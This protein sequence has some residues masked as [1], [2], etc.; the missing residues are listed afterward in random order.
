M[1]NAAI[2]EAEGPSEES[3]TV[4]VAADLEQALL[5]ASALIDSTVLLHRQ[6]SELPTPV[7]RTGIAPLGE[8]LESLVGR[9]RHTLCVAM[10]DTGE[11][12]DAVVRSL[13]AVPER[14]AVRILCTAETTNSSLSRLAQLADTR[15]ELR[16]SENELRETVVVDGATALVRATE[17][18]GGQA[19]VVNDAAAVRA[20]ELLFAGAWSRGRRLADH[21]R[22][23]P[24]LRTELARRILE[25]LRAGH[26]DET[27]AREL[28]VSLRTYRRYVAEIMRELHAN[29]RF[30]AGVRAVEFGLLSE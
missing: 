18:K 10:T 8:A 13:D 28:N 3:T 5:Q 20:L 16:V 14:A 7:A 17:E 19:A 29:S 9:T 23:S 6:R 1:S 15:L 30:Q 12:T 25:R 11:F 21:L 2:E 4:Q 27:A 22:L 26:T 24:R